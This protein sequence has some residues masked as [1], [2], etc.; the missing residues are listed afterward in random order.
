MSFII[1]YLTNE[2]LPEDEANAMT[3]RKLPA[4]YVMVAY[5]LYRIGA[6]QTYVEVLRIGR[7]GPSISGGA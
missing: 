3:M 4:R 7:G 2:E 6:V 5:K 1:R